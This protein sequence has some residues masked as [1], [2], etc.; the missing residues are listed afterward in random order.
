MSHIDLTIPMD[1]E[2]AAEY[3]EAHM[4]TTARGTEHWIRAYVKLQVSAD[5]R[6]VLDIEHVRQLAEELPRM[7]MAHDAAEHVRAEQVAAEKSAT[8]SL[9]A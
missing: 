9:A 2:V 6:L 7:L 5:A 1:D 4:L 8:Q 3:V